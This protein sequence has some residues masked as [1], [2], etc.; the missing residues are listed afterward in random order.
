MPEKPL[1]LTESKL[2]AVIYPESNQV[3]VGYDNAYKADI[4]FRLLDI[5]KDLNELNDSLN[6]IDRDIN[7]LKNHGDY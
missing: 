1:M 2:P 6:K 5:M 4:R 7:N 3:K